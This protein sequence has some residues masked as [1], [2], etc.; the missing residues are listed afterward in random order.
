MR[1]IFPKKSAGFTLI[2]MVFSL[3]LFTIIMF[4]AT[5]AFLSIVNTDRKARG[6]RIAADNL[7][8]A[9]EDMTRRI[10]T[11]TAYFCDGAI[12]TATNATSDACA[13]GGIGIAFTDQKGL[14]ERY[15]LNGS[16]I[17]RVIGGVTTPVTS[18]EITISNLKFVVSGS[19]PFPD[20]K[21][22][23][24]VVVAGGSLGNGSTASTFKIQTTIT[25]RTYDN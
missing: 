14:R 25:Q 20:T 8:I 12:S 7:N 21:Q 9:L 22:P 3:G 18:P 6:V 10:K 5:S 24:V 17:E 15:Q 23:S 2:E 19:D 4:I 1:K 11:G 16:V 13:S